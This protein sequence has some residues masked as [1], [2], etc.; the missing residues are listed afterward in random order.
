M[1]SIARIGM[2]G[3]LFVVLGFAGWRI[4]HL[5]RA[6][7]ALASDNAEVALQWIPA[8]PEALLKRAE[9][10]LADKR[11]D[12]AAQAARQ[13]L[14]VSPTDGRGYR[15]L[16]QIAERRDQHELARKLFT[17]AARRAPRDLIARAWLAQDA[18]ER[19]APAE[20]LVQIDHVLTLS[21][22]KGSAIFPV[23]VKLAANPEFADALAITMRRPPVWRSGMLTALQRAAGDD[24]VAAAQVLSALE[25]KGGFNA[26][27]TDAWTESLIREG[28]WGEAYAR[29][30]SPLVASGKPLPLLFNGNFA[31]QSNGNGFDWRMAPTAGVIIDFEPGRGNGRSLHARFLGRRVAGAFL[32]HRLLLAPGQYQLRV[33]QRADAL[34]SDLGLSWSLTCEGT[35]SL[36]ATSEPI[37]GTRSWQSIK[38]EFSV[39][40][41]QC[42][43]QW[44]RLGNAGVSGAGQLVSGDLWVEE[45]TLQGLGKPSDEHE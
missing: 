42:A 26:A 43:G 25:R 23:M 32:E 3:A 2:L 44:L 4:T 6:D 12:A 38:V 15:V 27:E 41:Q 36:L 21:P 17:I 45:A 16:A 33:R 5:M 1:R 24:R 22:Q 7:A 35:R 11:A 31:T 34:I 13:L 40:P 20:A 28:R 8:H 18:L 10:R 30:A 9:S 29:W 37:E 19:G 39:P 14:R